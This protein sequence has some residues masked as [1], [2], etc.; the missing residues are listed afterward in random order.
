M[1]R[2]TRPNL[3]VP[4]PRQDTALGP[5]DFNTPPP[6]SPPQEPV[7]PY[8]HPQA[9]TIP[10]VNAPINF[11]EQYAQIESNR[12]NR[13]AYQKLAQE[14]APQIERGKWAKLGSVLAGAATGFGQNNA[15]AGYN[16]GRSAYEAPQMRSDEAYDRKIKEFGSLAQL[17]DSDV[18]SKLSALEAQN[19]NYWASE[20]LRLK[21][22]AAAREERG[23][24]RADKL[25]E[26]QIKNM[27]ADNM[28]TINETD[29]YT[30]LY[31]KGTQLKH[32][33]GKTGYTTKEQYDNAIREFAKQE[34]IRAYYTNQH[35]RIVAATSRANN[36]DTNAQRAAAEQQKRDLAVAN[37]K[38]RATSIPPNTVAHNVVTAIASAV[39]TGDLPVD[40]NNYLQFDDNGAPVSK[41]PFFGGNATTEELVRQ[42][43]GNTISGVRN[44]SVGGGNTNTGPAATDAAG[45]SITPSTA[46]PASNVPG[47]VNPPRPRT[48]SP[49][50]A[51]APSQY[52]NPEDMPF[53]PWRDSEAPTG[54][55]SASAAP[56]DLNAFTSAPSNRRGFGPAPAPSSNAKRT[57]T[58]I[59]PPD[60]VPEGENPEFEAEPEEVESLKALGATV[61]PTKNPLPASPLGGKVFAPARNIS[62]RMAEGMTPAPAQLPPGFMQQEPGSVTPNRIGSPIP[63]PPAGRF[64]DEPGAMVAPPA[65]P[66]PI[67][68]TPAPVQN[69][70]PAGTGINPPVPAAPAAMQRSLPQTGWSNRTSPPPVAAPP[71]N[72]SPNI[73]PPTPAPNPIR[74]TPPPEVAPAPA[75]NISPAGAEMKPVPP[76]QRKFD[77]IL[78][79]VMKQV[80]RETGYKVRIREGYRS[81][82][83]QAEYYAK[84]RSAPGRIITNADG[85]IKQSEHQTAL[86]A[87]LEFIDK[88][89]KVIKPDDS[90]GIPTK[91]GRVIFSVLSK[92]AKSRGLTWGGDWVKPFD[93]THVQLYPVKQAPAKK[94]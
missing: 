26:A 60:E 20:D 7:S 70:A 55:P 50:G 37:L 57:V 18:S 40:A 52:I 15:T 24:T 19:R 42:H 16:L 87:D 35:D 12:P 3:F 85:K 41:A 81:P 22:D 21:K 25:L 27:A 80:Q 78:S 23:E 62:P 30:Y 29:G 71:M 83:K 51:S 88:N 68:P 75:R 73:A 8:N 82:E 43:I 66:T 33:I 64:L 1:P 34:E 56:P 17:E 39:A 2:T 45:P 94:K 47:P 90:R 36:M 61:H 31:D 67:S 4:Q 11:A 65:R 48:P 69:V 53:V 76:E 46:P 54:T 74:I 44:P 14:G 77:S 38:L 13:L 86:A 32:K 72:V 84:G 91:E 49:V 59:A 58:M 79:E 89:G 6:S 92:A 5:F 93:P 9:Q 10:G 63:R 28:I